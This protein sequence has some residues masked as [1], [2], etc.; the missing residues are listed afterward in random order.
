MELGIIGSLSG[1][2]AWLMKELSEKGISVTGYDRHTV[3]EI[4]RSK[5]RIFIIATPIATVSSIIEDLNLLSHVEV[6]V[7]VSSLKT[8]LITT[9]QSSPKEILSLH[10]MFGP[11][12]RSLQ[13]Q[14]ILVIKDSPHPLAKELL[15]LFKNN[16]AILIDVPLVTHDRLMAMVQLLPHLTALLMQRALLDSKLSLNE[17]LKVAPDTFKASLSLVTRIAHQSPAL[18]ESIIDANPGKGEVVQSLLNALSNTLNISGQ[19]ESFRGFTKDEELL[20]L[21]DQILKSIT[22]P[23]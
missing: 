22:K 5:E 14:R 21:S 3:G 23:S 2:G 9:L 17:L 10:P 13:N 16:G 20:S 15:T 11:R 6:I 12:V 1:L 19:I 7:E 8:P 4:N 18:T